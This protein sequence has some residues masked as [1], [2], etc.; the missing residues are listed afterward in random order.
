MVIPDGCPWGI[1]A[2]LVYDF[3]VKALAAY[4]DAVTD[5]D[6]LELGVERGEARSQGLSEGLAV[7]VAVRTWKAK[8]Q[9]RPLSLHLRGDSIA[10]LAMADKLCSSSPGMNYLG[11][12][13]S[14]LLEAT[15][16]ENIVSTENQILDKWGLHYNS[17]TR[18]ST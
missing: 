10:A 2:I 17:P 11:A 3:S 8:L 14:I 1:G 13:L 5:D 6:I 4:A 12:E 15:L 7:V 9:E 18:F 16:V